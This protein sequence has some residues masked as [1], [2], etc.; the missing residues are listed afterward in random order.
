MNEKVWLSVGFL[1][2]ATLVFAQSDSSNAEEEKWDVTVAHGTTSELEFTTDEGTW[3]SCDVSPDGKEIVFDL[4]GDI[5]VIPLTGGVAK[6]LTSGP[7]WD[8][9][10]AF[11]PHGDK[12]AFTSDRGGGDNIWSMNRDGS[13]PKEV[14]KEDFRLLNNPVFM[15]DGRYI[16]ARKHFV[17][18]RSLGAGEMW[19]YHISGGDGVQLTEKRDWQ[20]D[21]G[22]PDVSPDGR[23]LYFSQDA[24]PGERFEYNRNPYEGIYAIERVDLITGERK[25]IVGGPGG[26]ATPQISPDGKTVA[27]VRRVGLKTVLFVKDLTTGNERKVFDKLNRDAQETW[28]IFGVH[29]G[30]SWTPDGRH[31][32][33]SAKGRLWKVE[34]ETGSAQQ[35]PFTVNVKQTITEAIRFPVSVGDPDFQVRVIR[36]LRVS[37]DGEKVV[38]QALG[39]LYVANKDGSDRKLLT[40]SEDIFEFQPAWSPSG[41][42]VAFTTWKDGGAGGISVVSSKGG[43]AA[44]LDISPG[45]YFDPSWSPDGKFLVY[46]RGTGNWLRGF[47][48]TMKPGIH[49]VP[50]SGRRARFVTDEGTHPRFSRDGKR[51]TLHA[52]EGEDQALVSVDL[53]GKD[54]RVLAASQHAHSWAVSPDEEWIAFIER[55]HIYVA[56]FPHTGKQI[57]LSPKTTSLPIAKVTRD[58]GFG[59][60]WSNDSK[61]VYWT[62]GAELFSRPLRE[63]FTFVE[64]APDSLPEPDSAGIQL[65]WKEKGDIPDGR[66]ALMGARIITM[67]EPGIIENGIIV[68]EGNRIEKIGSASEIK[69]PRFTKKIDVSG[70]TV[71]PGFVDVHSHMSLNW[72]GL[73]SQQNWHYLA[74]LAFG[75]TT[76]HDPSN[77]TEIVFANSELQKAGEILAPR[78]YSTGMIL[79]GAETGFTAEVNSLE[80]AKSHLRRLR[81]F[82]AFSAKSY[83]QPRRA[84]RQQVLKAA[85]EIGM[86][87]LPEGGSTFQHNMNMI[88][89]GHTGIEHSIPVSPLYKDVL[90]LYGTSGVGYTPT[91]IVSYGGLWGENYWYQ[92][93]KVFEHER[94]LTYMPEELLDEVGRRRMMVEDND[95]NYIENAKA[96]KALADYGVRVNNGAHGQLV[97]LGVHWE[98]WMLAQGGMTPL[99]ALRASTLNG[100]A[101]IGLDLDLGSL[102]EGK[103]AD[104]VVLGKNPLENIRNSDSV[105]MVML[106]GRLFNASTMNEIAP[107]TRQR[108]AFW[109][110]LRE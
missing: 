15:P 10:P 52:R 57:K 64:G 14:T 28:A 36:H 72:D 45:H 35:I 96:A 50:R 78:V 51:I 89:D 106:N 49:M 99:E 38:F 85:R 100:A 26:A 97:G 29:P 5:Y 102:E 41:K 8:V 24:S 67:G 31:I 54:R 66:I 43:K 77:D 60:H 2:L 17:K 33:I 32:V 82:G 93:Q 18:T 70:K 21:A 108:R 56:Q 75:V 109:W 1:I 101:Y 22:E 95:Y 73:S 71:I 23:F 20:H 90:T 58:S 65:G 74:N 81:A 68:I 88:V 53:N 87:V 83:N 46:R 13:D 37:P 63:M 105:E 55:F 80:D 11:S 76:T 12:I 62:L 86:M 94:L 103:L 34:V 30:Y 16:V 69:V 47:E 6:A 3:I 44:K 92:H 19:M 48:N 7:A 9:Q 59:V 42:E 84:Q 39:R 110:E 107:E 104:L 25:Q 61:S 40:S 98:M 4:L 27:F 91:L 79:Y